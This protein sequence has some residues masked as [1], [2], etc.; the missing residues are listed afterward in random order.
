MAL[1]QTV[2]R[3]RFVTTRSACRLTTRCRVVRTSTLKPCT[4]TQWA[5]AVSLRST[6]AI[7][8]KLRRRRRTRRL[9]RS[10]CV[11]AS[12]LHQKLLV[13]QKGAVRGTFFLCARETCVRRRQRSA[14]L[15]D[16]E[17]RDGLAQPLGLLVQRAC[18]GRGLLDKRG[19]ALR[20]V[21]HLAN[22][23]VHFADA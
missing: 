17:H 23:E 14:G 6:A 11:T 18:G 7:S 5:T 2:A 9:L 21:V 16:P 8:R 19:V 3:P 1:P 4:S 13:V 12:K 15:P 10:V 20:D 22:R